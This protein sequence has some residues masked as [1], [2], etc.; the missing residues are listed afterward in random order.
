[1]TDQRPPPFRRIRHRLGPDGY[2]LEPLDK[3]H[4]PRLGAALSAI[5]PWATYRLAAAQ[6]TG[7][8]AREDADA[9]R[10]AILRGEAIIGAA[11]I[12][13]P[14][15]HGPYLQFLGLVPGEQGAGAGGLVLAWMEAE[16]AGRARNLWL[17]VTESNTRAQAFYARRGFAVAANLDGLAA[18]G[19]GERLMRKRLA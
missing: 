9:P 8:L 12:Q 4:A 11:V 15:L 7:F 18:D 5:E 19:I 13:H 1:M 10:F 16:V 3:V 6:L 17:C 2:A 14:W